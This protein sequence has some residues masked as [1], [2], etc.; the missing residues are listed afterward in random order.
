MR[1]YAQCAESNREAIDDEQQDLEP[2]DAVN[3]AVEKLFGEDGVFL[4]EFREVI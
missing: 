2:D 1:H 4:D 3:E